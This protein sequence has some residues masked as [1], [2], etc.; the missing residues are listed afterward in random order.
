M[1]RLQNEAP[2]F[3][4]GFSLSLSILSLEANCRAK[5]IPLSRSGVLP[6]WVGNEGSRFDDSYFCALA[7]CMYMTA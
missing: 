2:V 4:R 3:A 1:G 7:A 5:A 6:L